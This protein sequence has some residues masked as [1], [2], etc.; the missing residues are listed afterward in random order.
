MTHTAGTVVLIVGYVVMLAALFTAWKVEP[1]RRALTI[2]V[3][4]LLIGAAFLIVGA[5]NR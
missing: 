1:V 3:A 2:S 5:L 4:L